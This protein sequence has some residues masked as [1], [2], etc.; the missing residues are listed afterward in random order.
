MSHQTH[1]KNK[2]KHAAQRDGP[3]W[4]EG[5]QGMSLKDTKE[6]PPVTPASDTDLKVG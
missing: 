3:G 4:V 2:P 5:M 6:E 1:A